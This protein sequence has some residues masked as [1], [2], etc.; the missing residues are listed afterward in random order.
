[1]REDVDAKIDAVS[2]LQAEF[3]KGSEVRIV[4]QLCAVGR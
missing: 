2:K 1:M 4:C 3:E